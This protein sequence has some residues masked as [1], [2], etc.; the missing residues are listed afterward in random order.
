MFTFNDIEPAKWEKFC[1]KRDA[2]FD[3]IK[4]DIETTKKKS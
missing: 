1:K 4:R 3:R 2:L